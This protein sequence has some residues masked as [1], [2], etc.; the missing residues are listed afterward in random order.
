[1]ASGA[2]DM[3]VRARVVD[4]LAEALDG[5][6]CLRHGDDAARFRPADAGAARALFA[7]LAQRARTAWLSSSAPSASA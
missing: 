5:V 4:T 7:A 6:T 2:A 1:M 3:L